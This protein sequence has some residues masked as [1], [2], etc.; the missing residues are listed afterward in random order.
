MGIPSV[1]VFLFFLFNF[2]P[3]HAATTSECGIWRVVRSPNP[4]TTAGLNGVAALSARNVWAVGSYHNTGPGPTQLTLVE[5]WNGARWNVVASPNPGTTEDSLL[6]TASVPG[7]QELWAVGYEDSSPIGP[8]LVP[9]TLIERWDGT[10][11]RVVPS[12]NVGQDINELNGVVALSTTDAWAVGEH[13]SATSSTPSQTL[14]EH[15]NGTSWSIVPSPNPSTLNGNRLTAIAAV[16]T[17]DIWAVG[18]YQPDSGGLRDATL[19][20]HWDGTSWSVVPSPNPGSFDDLFMGVAVD[21]PTSIWAVGTS[22]GDVGSIPSTLIE[23]WNGST[24]SVVASP[25]PGSSFNALSAVVSL[26]PTNAW[27]VGYFLQGNASEQ[28]LTLQWNG[29]DWTT[30]QSP[31]VGLDNNALNALSSVPVTNGLWAVGNHFNSN[32]GTSAG[33][34]MFHC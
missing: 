4:S 10:S 24:W 12:P 25:N 32:T 30:V 5:R 29:T 17:K 31:N 6:A 7:S 18:S 11:W 28:T 33:L 15:W 9:Q 3:V 26:S 27:A 16:S 14:I 2:G 22:T 1:I 8:P 19:A 23:H 20:E 13:L 21:S 34:T